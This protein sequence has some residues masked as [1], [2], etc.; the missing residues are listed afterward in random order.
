MPKLAKV[1]VKRPHRVI[2]HPKHEP[3]CPHR[4]HEAGYHY[5]HCHICREQDDLSI[6]TTSASKHLRYAL[7]DL[8]HGQFHAA[9]H[10]FV[11]AF[12]RATNTGEYRHGGYFD[13]RFPGWRVA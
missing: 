6:A 4:G 11:W 8:A 3:P 2:T 7:H 12:T 10:Q 13:G 5:G 1:P 9:L